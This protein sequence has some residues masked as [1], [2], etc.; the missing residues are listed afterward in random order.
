MSPALVAILPPLLP[1]Y[2]IV[3]NTFHLVYSFQLFDG[4]DDFICLWLAGSIAK[5]SGSRGLMVVVASSSGL[6]MVL[7]VQMCQQKTR[8]WQ[9]HC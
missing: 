1:R 7:D 2:L 4:H 3:R 9:P 8:V 6:Q 5:H